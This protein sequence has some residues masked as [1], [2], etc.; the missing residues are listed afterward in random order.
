ME[1]PPLPTLLILCTFMLCITAELSQA[2]VFRWKDDNGKAVFGDTPPKDNTAI[3]V[4]IK[5][6]EKS[7]ARFATP[8]QMKDIEN[9][10]EA[11]RRQRQ[12]ASQNTTDSHCRGYVSELNKIEIF[13]QHTPTDLDRQK[14]KDL[15]KLIKVECNNKVLTQKY[16]DWQCKRYRTDLTKAEIFLEHTPTTIDQQKIIDLK[17]Q[18]S[19][20]CH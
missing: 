15:R 13:L 16:D 18:I 9:S 10:A 4:D 2:E 17:N 8:D 6:I 5:N 11:R 3:A 19:R 7:G 14:A 20:E 1:Q 12:A